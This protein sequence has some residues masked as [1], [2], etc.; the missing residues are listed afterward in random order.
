M[1]GG[2]DT[3]HGPG[4]WLTIQPF[5]LPWADATVPMGSGCVVTA[6]AQHLLIVPLGNV[7]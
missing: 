5:H 1:R 2:L 3:T 4:T 6:G 7:S